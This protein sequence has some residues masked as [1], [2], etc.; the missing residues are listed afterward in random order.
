[1]KKNSLIKIIKKVCN[2]ITWN[3]PRKYLFLGSPNHGNLGDHCIA[4]STNIFFK[5]YCKHRFYEISLKE[6][7]RFKKNIIAWRPRVIAIIGGGN[8]GDLWPAEEN[9]HLD[10]IKTFKYSKIVMMPQSIWFENSDSNN[11]YYVLMKDIY[12]SHR[13]LYLFARDRFSYTFMKKMF[14]NNHVYLAPDMVLINNM[15][16]NTCSKNNVLVLKRKDKE[17]CSSGGQ[18]ISEAIDIFFK[19]GYSVEYMDTVLNYSVYKKNRKQH[20]D[21]LFEKIRNSKIVITDRLHGMIFS[22]INSTP[23]IVFPN[24]NTKIKGSYEWIKDNHSVLYNP[25]KQEIEKFLPI[26]EES[27]NV[28]IISKY[29]SLRSVLNDKKR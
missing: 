18:G 1:M 9:F 16:K 26:L 19:K 17:A 12:N 22:Y 29:D 5:K 13:D 8:M 28:N 10:V 24:N 27:S 14:P 3:I 2:F 11:E 20:I 6:Y 23:V 21:K 7:Y 15:Q 4:I 25:S